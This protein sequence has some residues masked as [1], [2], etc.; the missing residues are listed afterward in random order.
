MVNLLKYFV[1]EIVRA[2]NRRKGGRLEQCDLKQVLLTKR[3]ARSPERELRLSAAQGTVSHK[4][5]EA[6]SVSSTGLFLG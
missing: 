5:K 3:L 4:G 2:E 6:A 1:G